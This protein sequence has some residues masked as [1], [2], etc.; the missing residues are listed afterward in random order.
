MK[1]KKTGRID[2]QP[3]HLYVS[4]NPL[5]PYFQISQTD[6]VSKTHAETSQRDRRSGA[7]GEF[8]LEIFNTFQVFL[9]TSLVSPNFLISLIG[10]D[11]KLVGNAVW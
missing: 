11:F 3:L 9:L 4:P 5:L 2:S 8:L 10:L 1:K 7:W 6:G